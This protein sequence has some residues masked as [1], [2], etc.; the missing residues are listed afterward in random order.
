MLLA[1]AMATPQEVL[2]YFILGVVGGLLPD[3][4]AD[5]SLSVRLLF[6][7]IATV[8]SF[9][10]MFKQQAD[11][12]LIELFLVWMGSFVF[13]K[14]FL[15]SLFTKVTVHRGILHSIP[16]SILFGFITT[17]LLNHI[18]HFN[19]FVAWMGG[20]F[21]FGGCITHLLLDELYSLNFAGSGPKKSAGTALKFGSMGDL[22]STAF[23]YLL[24]GLLFIA[25]PEYKQFFSVILDT[26]TYKHL[27]IFPKGQWFADFCSELHD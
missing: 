4:D 14:Y 25:T 15:F 19:N 12:T 24:I 5:N 26:A 21:I 22:K 9:L 1:S 20:V 10:V 11:N 7:F 23:I 18:F 2:L 8:I 27:E 16:A 3:V 17:I 6:T 13:I